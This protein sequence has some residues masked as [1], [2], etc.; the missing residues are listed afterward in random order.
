M[1]L[2]DGNVKSERKRL[3][4]KL[5]TLF[6]LYIRLRDRRKYGGYCVFGCG[7]S[8]DCAFH[9]I[10]R[11]KHSVRWRE[12]N[13]AGSCRGCNMRNEY[14]PHGYVQWYVKEH[15]QEAWDTLIRDGNKTAKFSMDDLLRI[16]EELEGKLGGR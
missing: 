16:K 12:E 3:V 4:A 2:L 8:I 6:S 14:D 10:T 13:A 1:D 9:F 11:T 5:D 15:G 7:K